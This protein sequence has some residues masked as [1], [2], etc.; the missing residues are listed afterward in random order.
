MHVNHPYDNRGSPWQLFVLVIMALL[1][2]DN[3]VL[4][5]A[6]ADVDFNGQRAYVSDGVEAH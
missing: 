1:W 5:K 2:N 6:W 3:I 4:P